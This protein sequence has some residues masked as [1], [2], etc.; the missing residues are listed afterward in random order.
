MSN[1][2]ALKKFMKQ[3]KLHIFKIIFQ[4]RKV[5]VASWIIVR[6]IWFIIRIENKQ[7]FFS[8]FLVSLPAKSLCFKCLNL[9]GRFH[10]CTCFEA[11]QR[12]WVIYFG[13]PTLQQQEVITTAS[14]PFYFSLKCH[15]LKVSSTAFSKIH[16]MEMQFIQALSGV[17]E[18]KCFSC[19][20]WPIEDESWAVVGFILCNTM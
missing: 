5:F 10:K 17:V 7:G 2:S 20:W 13:S 18:A 4:L 1:S 9:A 11:P 12:L 16:L 6:K 15:F 19:N 14:L 8:F 3:W